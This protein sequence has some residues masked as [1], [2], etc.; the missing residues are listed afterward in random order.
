MQVSQAMRSG[1]V[2]I[3]PF[4][5]LAVAASTMRALGATSL[6]VCEDRRL[7]GVL[8]ER[9]LKARRPDGLDPWSTPVR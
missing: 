8:T 1:F 3:S 2:G 9:T 6:L 4:A 7:V 5:S